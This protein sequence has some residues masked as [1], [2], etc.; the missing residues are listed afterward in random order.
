M[1][2]KIVILNGVNL[3]ELG[4]REV[5]VYGAMSF[6]NYFL[7]LK[8]TF[9]ELN[10]SYRQTNRVDELVE[11]ILSKQYDGIVLNPGAYTHTSLVIADAIK[12][13]ETPVIEVHISNLFGR[14]NYRKNSMIAS[15]CIGCVSGF[16]LRSYELS[17]YYFK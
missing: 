17:L 5:D 6:E 10:L 8:T 13:V 7:K 9:P 1:K 11:I 2:K 14:E 4:T 16:G 12:A 3:G 15:C